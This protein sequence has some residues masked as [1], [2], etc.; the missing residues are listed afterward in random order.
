MQK[1]QC[2]IK[3]ILCFNKSLTEVKNAPI[4]LTK[5]LKRYVTT[6][7]QH[8]AFLYKKARSANET[9]ADS[10]LFLDLQFPRPNLQPSY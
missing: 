5:F 8:L 4:N 1:L 3:T 6:T 9:A 7:S 10:A 2:F